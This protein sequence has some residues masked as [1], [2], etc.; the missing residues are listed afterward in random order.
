MD[1]SKIPAVVCSLSTPKEQGFLGHAA[2]KD[3]STKKHRIRCFIVEFD[4]NP[5]TTKHQKKCFHK[6]A[7]YKA[8]STT[9]TT[10]THN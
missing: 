10:A 4:E 5:S 2:S 3:G 7:I 8:H 1:L 6:N 9:M